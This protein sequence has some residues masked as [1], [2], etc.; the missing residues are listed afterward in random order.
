MDQKANIPSQQ[1]TLSHYELSV[2]LNRLQIESIP[3]FDK[4]DFALNDAI[5]DNIARRVA[6]RSL[7]ARG[8]LQSDPEGDLSNKIHNSL[9]TIMAVCSYGSPTLFIYHWALNNLNPDKTF[10]HFHEQNLVIHERP[11][12]MHRFTWYSSHTPLLSILN[13]FVSPLTTDQQQASNHNNRQ[14]EMTLLIESS[15]FDSIRDLAG[16]QKWS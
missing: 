12:Q 4:P 6:E 9:L 5:K 11:S 16:N 3:G 14:G 15:L 10:V 1:I 7:L 2:I 13:K 8:L